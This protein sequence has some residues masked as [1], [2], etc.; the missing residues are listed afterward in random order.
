MIKRVFGFSLVLAILILFFLPYTNKISFKIDIDP[1]SVLYLMGKENYL[2]ELDDKEVVFSEYSLD[3]QGKSF[4]Y[5]TRVKDI[6]NG[7]S[8]LSFTLDYGNDRLQ[9][10]INN[11]LGINRDFTD[12]KFKIRETRS[13]ISTELSKFDLGP[14]ELDS[15]ESSKCICKRFVSNIDQKASLMNLNIDRLASNLGSGPKI[16]P[17]LVID[18]LNFVAD[19]LDFSLCFPFKGEITKDTE[20]ITRELDLDKLNYSA[21]FTGNYS[22]SHY[23]WARL[24][25]KLFESGKL[26][27]PLIET[28]LDNPFS[29]S[30]DRNWRSIVLFEMEP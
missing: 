9:R 2:K 10:R 30:N 14:I 17:I 6:G 18:S 26:K 4:E 20:F 15:I 29:L 12:F 19:R 27:Y 13:S 23:N 3:S 5:S 24:Y 8:Y 21:E 11:W 25:Y 1:I 7:Q 16:P 28:Y 22:L